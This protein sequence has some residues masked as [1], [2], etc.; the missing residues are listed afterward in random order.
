MS[1]PNEYIGIPSRWA[2]H[3]D[4]IRL[5]WEPSGNEVEGGRMGEENPGR[6]RRYDAVCRGL[7]LNLAGVEQTLAG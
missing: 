3:I 4:N 1:L 2:I 6:G 5:R 7:P